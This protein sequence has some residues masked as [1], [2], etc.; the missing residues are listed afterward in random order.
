MKSCNTGIPVTMLLIQYLQ[1]FSI[2]CTLE[3]LLF[4][5]EH[6]DVLSLYNAK[7]SSHITSISIHDKTRIF[8]RFGD[9]SDS[10]YMYLF[11]SLAYFFFTY[12]MYSLRLAFY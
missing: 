11:L 5:P 9:Y 12:R 1:I 3:N 10:M 8:V 7:V 6:A 2:S 4:F